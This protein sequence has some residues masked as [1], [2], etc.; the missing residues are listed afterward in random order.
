M[1]GQLSSGVLVTREGEGHTAYAQGNA[2]IDSTVDAYLLE[3]TVPSTDPL[4]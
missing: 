1:A 3:G 2:C 4:C